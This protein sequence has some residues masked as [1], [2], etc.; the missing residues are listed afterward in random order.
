[1]PPRKK[2]PAKRRAGKKTSRGRRSG[3]VITVDFTNVDSGGG[4]LTPDGYYTAEIKS[5]EEE[6]GGDSGEPYLAVRWK[7]HIGSVVFDNFS[8]Q[9]Q[10]LWVLRSCLDCMGYDTPD[11]EYE[12]D[13]DDLLGATCG[14]EVVNEEYEGRDRPKAVGYMP[15]DVAEAS[16]LYIARDSIEEEEEEQE[17][18]EEEEEAPPPKSKRRAAAKKK[19]PAK[20]KSTALRPGARVTFEDDNEDIIPGVI[21]FVEDDMATVVDDN[22]DSWEIPLEELTKA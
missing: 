17:E 9:P 10:S 3:N 21:E 7:T 20:K 8:L 11:A 18:Q 16:D 1:M 5:I 19:A 6:V 22:E 15:V 4:M 14:L 13:P 12:F 2:A